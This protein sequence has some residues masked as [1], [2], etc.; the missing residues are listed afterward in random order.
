[1]SVVQIA[2][3]IVSLTAALAYLNARFVKLPSGIG[4]MAIS[5]VGSLAVIALDAAG[6]IDGAGIERVV[7]RASFGETLL[8]GMLGLLLFAGAVQLDARELATQ[9]APVAVLALGGTVLATVLVGFAIYG[10]FAAVGLDLPLIEAMLFGA[11]ISPTDPVAVLS[12]VKVSKVPRELAVQISGESLFNDVVGVVLVTVMLAIAAGSSVTAP[13]VVWLFVRVAFGGAA[14]G[15]AMGLIGRYLLRSIDTY[16]VEV[17]ITLALVLG[18]YAAAEAI[19]VSAPI[20]AVV[21]GLVIANQGRRGDRRVG[22]DRRRCRGTRARQQ[23]ARRVPPRAVLG[24]RRRGAQRGAVPHA[25]SRGDAARR[26]SRARDRRRDRR[27][28]HARRSPRVGRGLAART[29][30][31]VGARAAAC[32][33]RAHV[34]R[35]ARRTIGRTRAVAAGGHAPRR[36]ADDDVRG[37]VLRDPRARPHARARAAPTRPVITG[38]YFA[39]I[40]IIASVA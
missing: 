25:R 14:F 27:A 21:A 35:A 8:H 5:L 36:V 16:S 3:I 11:L 13:G 20:G 12:V 19:H 37:R 1:M 24:A 34:G 7:T 40:G 39:S 26:Q 22:T 2:A 4:L 38:G 9:R 30:T 28:D 15:L 10:V 23:G 29:A 33:D 18:G 17:L 32:R 31:A 6:V